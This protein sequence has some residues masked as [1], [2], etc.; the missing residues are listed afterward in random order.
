MREIC[1]SGSEGGGATALPTPIQPWSDP[2]LSRL[3]L[4]AWEHY[5]TA[6]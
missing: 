4:A 2:V 1:T 6:A 3:D 5:Q